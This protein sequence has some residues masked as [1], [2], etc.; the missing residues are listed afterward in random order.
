[1]IRILDRGQRWF[2]VV[3]RYGL[4]RRYRPKIHLVDP[5]LEVGRYVQD[6]QG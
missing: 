6:R 4:A 2:R 1:M 3:R 5:K